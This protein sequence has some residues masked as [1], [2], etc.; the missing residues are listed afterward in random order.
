VAQLPPPTVGDLETARKTYE[1]NERRAVVYR[2]ARRLIDQ[3]IGPLGESV[4]VLLLSWNPRVRFESAALAAVIDETDALRHDVESRALES[5]SEEDSRVVTDLF[6]RFSAILGPVGAAKAL[7]V[8]HPNFFML[9]DTA[10]ASRYCGSGWRYNCPD[11]YMRFML[12]SAE[13]S[14]SCADGR[15]T[16]GD[17]L[18]KILD[19]RNYCILTKRWLPEL[20]A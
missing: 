13:Q 17:Q 7:A 1:A 14:Q 12:I 4:Q 18:P 3:D 20:S 9:W 2:A 6:E 19:E 15:Q 10:I 8:L 16:F 11:K 5:L